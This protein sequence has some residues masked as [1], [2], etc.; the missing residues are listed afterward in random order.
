MQHQ[1]DTRFHQA[2][3]DKERSSWVRE[4]E[5][6]MQRYSD[7]LAAV[8]AERDALRAQLEGE[9]GQRQTDAA[10]W[11]KMLALVELETKKQV[12]ITLAALAAP[13]CERFR[14]CSMCTL[15]TANPPRARHC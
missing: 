13:S 15:P 3:W 10:A 8:S 7:A 6:L 5:D 9:K 12:S 4:H 14:D 1:V 11:K 2:M